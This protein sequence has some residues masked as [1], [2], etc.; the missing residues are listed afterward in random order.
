ML[1]I[2]RARL[3]AELAELREHRVHAMKELANG[4]RARGID[5]ADGHE[6]VE[7]RGGLAGLGAG[8]AA[9]CRA[10]GAGAIRGLGDAEMNREQRPTKLVGEVPVAAWKGASDRVTENEGLARSDIDI[11]L[12]VREVQEGSL[13]ALRAGS[14]PFPAKVP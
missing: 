6:A 4:G 13:P 1:T 3:R 9:A 12:F 5:D 11:E 10:I 8:D 14:C 2:T 7:R